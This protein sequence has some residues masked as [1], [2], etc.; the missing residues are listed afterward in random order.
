MNGDGSF[1]AFDSLDA[2]LVANDRNHDLDVFV[3]D[4]SAGTNIL[5][6]ARDSA[7]ASD[8]PNS[9][10]VLY[11]RGVSADGRRIVFSSDG[12]NLISVD[13]NG[14]RD[15]FVRDL[16]P[17]TNILVSAA[18]NGIAGDNLSYEGALSASGRFVAFTS[19]ADNLVASDANK[20]ED[21]FVR[22]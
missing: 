5:I 12:D 11:P 2:S 14:C 3:R 10:S 9:S 13:T 19:S 17:G 18:T 22:D 15:V 1:A 20:R 4:V 21:V 7:L 16:V 6:S 8:S